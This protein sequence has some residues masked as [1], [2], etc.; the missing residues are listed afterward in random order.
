MPLAAPDQALV[1][2]AVAAIYARHRPDWHV[3]GA[4][5]RTRTGR[6]FTGVQLEASVGGV[7]ACGMCRNLIADDVPGAR[8]L[9]PGTSARPA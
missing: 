2:T 7:A 1:D 6:V 4:A 9:L 5:L 3:V 8:W